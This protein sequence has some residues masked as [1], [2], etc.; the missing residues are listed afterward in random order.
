MRDRAQSGQAKETAGSFDRMN[1]PKDIV[2][3]GRIVRF[4]LKFHQ[5][6]VK[7]RDVFGRFGE[8]FAE[9]LIHSGYLFCARCDLSELA[10]EQAI[11]LCVKEVK[12]P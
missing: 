11:A 12:K 5:F 1:K 2:D 8:K 7:R 10:R 4:L 3:Q 9:Q 6:D